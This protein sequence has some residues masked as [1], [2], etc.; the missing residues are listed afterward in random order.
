MSKK[1]RFWGR[2]NKKYGKRAQTVSKSAWQ[3]LYHIHR[4]LP[5]KLS[6]KKSLLLT[7][8]IL[9]LLVNTLAADGKYLVL[10]RDNLTIPIQMQLSHKQK[11]FSEVF[12]AFLKCNFNFKHFLKKDD[13]HRFCIFE[14][15][16]SKNVVRLMSKKSEFRGCVD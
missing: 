8:E 1:S 7:C 3:H 12:T 13:P 14:V 11:T 5:R 9:G 15:R 4:S 2:F 6:W 16:D 10:D